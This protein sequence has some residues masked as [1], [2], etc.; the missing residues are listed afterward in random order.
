[1]GV[2]IGSNAVT[3]AEKVN[4]TRVYKAERDTLESSKAHRIA[5]CNARS[6]ENDLLEVE[7]VVYGAGIAE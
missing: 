1:M 7:G 4:Q 6:L 5:V 3:H 2:E